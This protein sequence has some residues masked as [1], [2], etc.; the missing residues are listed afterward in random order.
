MP[1]RSPARLLAPLALAAA[2]VALFA[3]VS[4]PGETSSTAPGDGERQAATAAPATTK[5]NAK[6]PRRSDARTYTVKPGD[7]P[8]GIAQAQDVDLAALLEANPDAD[9]AA[10]TPGQKLELP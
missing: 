4:S 3:V 10:L 5:T 8:S 7:T 1:G 2:A 6:A 9:P